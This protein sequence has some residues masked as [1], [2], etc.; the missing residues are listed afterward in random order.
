MYKNISNLMIAQLNNVVLWL[1]EPGLWLRNP[2][3]TLSF[4]L[5]TGESF[6]SFLHRLSPVV[7][8]TIIDPETR[9]SLIDILAFENAESKGIYLL[10]KGK[11][12]IKGLA[13][14]EGH[15]K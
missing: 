6:T 9:Q 13:V 8:I 12:L 1:Y 3:K 2:G 5:E 7:N 14:Q 4:M 11:I 10:W 15:T